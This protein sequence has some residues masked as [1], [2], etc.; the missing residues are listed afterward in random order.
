MTAHVPKSP[1]R[2][3]HVQRLNG[4]LL[5]TG[6][7]MGPKNKKRAYDLSRNPL[8]SMVSDTGFEPVTST[9]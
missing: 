1:F 9:V 8:I 3:T 7:Q 2:Q 5:A 4:P 6:Y